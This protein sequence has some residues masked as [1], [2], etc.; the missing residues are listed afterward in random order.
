MKLAMITLGT[1]AL[2]MTGCAHSKMRGSVAMKESD[3]EAHV[4]LDRGDVKVGDKVQLFSNRCTGGSKMAGRTCEKVSGG[5]GVVSEIISDHYSRVTFD[6]GV[7]FEEG[8]FVE[9]M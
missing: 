4:C 6:E 2:I 8:N 5:T 3:R 7:K 9:K 1:V